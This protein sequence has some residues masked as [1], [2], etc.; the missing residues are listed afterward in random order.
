MCVCACVR[1]HVQVCV[2]VCVYMNEKMPCSDLS[3]L[4]LEQREEMHMLSKS[5]CL[6]HQ[7]DAV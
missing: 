7:P 6:M 4:K 2:R 3:S 5:H 1:A